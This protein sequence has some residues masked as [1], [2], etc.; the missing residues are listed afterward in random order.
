MHRALLMLL[1]L[2]L[3]APACRQAKLYQ[4]NGAIVQGVILEGTEES[5]LVRDKEIPRVVEIPRE[6]LIYVRH[7]GRG[8]L[9]AGAAIAL[10]YGTFA[11]FALA[12]SD[13]EAA[14]YQAFAASAGAALSG[15][16]IIGITLH[17]RHESQRR[18]RE[19]APVPTPQLTDND[20]P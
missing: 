10:S 15:L 6:D 18:F 16:T 4:R 13:G 3:C 1:V 17:L 20:A 11:G 19:Q 8:W 5:V 14:G 12:Q 2:M 7:P 9:I